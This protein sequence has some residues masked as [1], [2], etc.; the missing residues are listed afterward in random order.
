MPVQKEGN[1]DIGVIGLAVMGQN[2]IMNMNDHHFKVVCFNRTTTKVD[3]FLQG[4]AKGTE[5]EG[6]RSLEEFFGKLKRPRRG[7]CMI[8]AGDPVDELI[9]EGLPYL[10]AGGG[11]ID[12]GN[13]HFPDS[14]RRCNK[15][16]HKGILFVGCGVSGGEVGARFG[17]SLMPGGNHD[18]WSHIKDIFQTIAA[19]TE[20]GEPCCDW[21]GSG[22]AGHYV[23]MVHNGIEYGDIQIICEAYDLLHR[24]LGMNEDQLSKIFEKWNRGELNSYL[25]DVASKVFAY[26][27][28]DGT[29]LVSKILDVAMQK[30]TGKWTG[31]SA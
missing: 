10:Q 8:K 6:A 27:D 13:S 3:T 24:V 30:G 20:K 12:G 28:T 19:K 16:K 22:G 5:V 26:P 4:P 17:P 21:V 25:I 11:F 18:A 7:M 15:L 29:P 2:L 9:D 31:Q 23:K 14:E 1:C